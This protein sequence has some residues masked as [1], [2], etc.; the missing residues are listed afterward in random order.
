M[1]KRDAAGSHPP[2]SKYFPKHANLRIEG[3][4]RERIPIAWNLWI[5]LLSY[6]DYKLRAVRVG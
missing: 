6:S 5:P 4:D 2:F 1:P 3:A